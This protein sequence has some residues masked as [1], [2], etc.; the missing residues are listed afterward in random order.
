MGYFTSFIPL[1]F[2][3][4]LAIAAIRLS[5]PFSTESPSKAQGIPGFY[6][7]SPTGA[8]VF[9]HRTSTV[10][11]CKRHG[12]HVERLEWKDLDAPSRAQGGVRREVG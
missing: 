6:D 5:H 1:F 7:F 2:C 9:H 8:G 10:E 4:P 12:Y 3:A 11:T